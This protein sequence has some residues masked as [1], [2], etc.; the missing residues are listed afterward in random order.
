MIAMNLSEVER[1]LG[2]T[3]GIAYPKLIRD[4]YRQRDWMSLCSFCETV[5]PEVVGPIVSVRAQQMMQDGFAKYGLNKYKAGATEEDHYKAAE[6][7]L[8][9]FGYH[10]MMDGTLSG[11]KIAATCFRLTHLLRFAFNE[12]A[13]ETDELSSAFYKN[14]SREM[15]ELF[16]G[17]MAEMILK[18]KDSNYARQSWRRLQWLDRFV[19]RTTYKED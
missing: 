11:W 7:L 9:G 18:M 1:K 10:Y 8:A 3:S 19:R 2:L 4:L 15:G 6:Y 5:R 12:Y 14:G 13:A 16:P 17:V